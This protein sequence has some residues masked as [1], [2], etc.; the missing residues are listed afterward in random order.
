MQYNYRILFFR[1]FSTLQ[2]D[3]DMFVARQWELYDAVFL[4]VA[5]TLH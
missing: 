1:D 2:A 5:V 4:N 3:A